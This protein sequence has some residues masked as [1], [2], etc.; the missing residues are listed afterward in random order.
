MLTFPISSAEFR[1]VHFEQAPLLCKSALREQDF[2]WSSLDE[3]LDCIE[4]DERGVQLFKQGLVPQT[5]YVHETVE[6]GRPRRR[7]DHARFY[8][9][10][11]TGA[12]LVLNRFEDHSTLV[13][14]LCADVARYAGL[15]T[16]ANAYVSFGGTGTFGRHWDTHDVFA[17][18]LL[19]RKRWQLYKPTLP[20]P[21]SHQTSD[22]APS[23]NIGPAAM[24][25]VLEPGD[26]L[27]VPRGWWHSVVPFN[28][29]SC[30]VSVGTYAATVRD[31]LMWVCSQ[32]FSQ[33][34]P[35]RRAFPPASDDRAAL[36]EML[37]ELR[38]VAL[39]TSVWR[40][41]AAE[42]EVRERHHGAT[43]L[44]LHA[45]QAP[46]AG[47]A[48]LQLTMSYTPAVDDHVLLV[49]GRRVSLDA[50][51]RAVFAALASGAALTFD[52]LCECV[53]MVPRD[54]VVATVL[55]FARYE[56]ITVRQPDVS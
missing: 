39:D 25:V 36:A 38:D 4:P 33:Q 55:N 2:S 19:G 45:G 23:Q 14:R 7:L 12:T 49:G 28:A 24:D 31:Y 8:D 1:A 52:A 17:I 6:F 35:A 22:A 26:L 20:L 44:A 27:Y 18:Q 53:D 10:L 37:H 46:L 41:F 15:Q 16:T 5:Q 40:R 32:F 11:R 47:A 43:N 51:G 3:I 48:R 50:V 54:A 29:G 34:L 42:L 30:H 9:Q 56:L 13:Q 21:L